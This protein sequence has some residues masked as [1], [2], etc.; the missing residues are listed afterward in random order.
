MADK[1]ITAYLS[2]NLKKGFSAQELRDA[3]LREGYSEKDVD[4]AIKSL[5]AAKKPAAGKKAAPANKEKPKAK[6]AGQKQKPGKSR[7]KY[8]AIE[9]AAIVGLSDRLKH[10]PSEL[11]G[12]QQQRVAIARALANDP[13]ILLADEPTGN[14]D[15]VSGREVIQI[16][17]QLYHEGKTIVMV[18]HDPK[19][20]SSARR[21]VQMNDG[22]IASDE[23]V[24]IPTG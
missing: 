4:E 13:L 12:G 10:H 11:S 24:G 8:L 7:K 23:M 21:I 1:K 2:E 19:V 15:S 20:A 17:E 6:K 3:L 16:L 14:L 22:Q 5:G 18:T 9:L